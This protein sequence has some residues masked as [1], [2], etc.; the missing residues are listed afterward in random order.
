MRRGSTN[1]WVSGTDIM[2]MSDLV[3]LLY[4]L[5]IITLLQLNEI[6]MNDLENSFVT[7]RNSHG[8]YR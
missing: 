7:K 8:S 3:S 4:A 6:L 5:R 2:A 1:A